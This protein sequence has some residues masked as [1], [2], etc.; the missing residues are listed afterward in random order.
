M[1]GTTKSFWY[2]SRGRPHLG[3]RRPIRTTWDK[4]NLT[5]GDEDCKK[6]MRE[7]CVNQS[8]SITSSPCAKTVQHTSHPTSDGI[9]TSCMPGLEETSPEQRANFDYSPALDNSWTGMRMGRMPDGGMKPQYQT[10]EGGKMWR[11]QTYKTVGQ[12]ANK[13]LRR[14]AW[15]RDADSWL[16]ESS[17]Q[18]MNRQIAQPRDVGASHQS[19]R[20]PRSGTQGGVLISSPDSHDPDRA[21]ASNAPIAQCKG[22]TLGQTIEQMFQ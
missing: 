22:H 13:R 21:T 20:I 2:P 9:P 7:V 4:V 16:E 17:P 18:R 15:M 5:Q 8:E 6:P 3:D 19:T 14:C 11:H 1:P 12:S 10:A